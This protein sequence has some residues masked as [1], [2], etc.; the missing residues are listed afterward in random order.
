MW[1]K[2]WHIWIIIEINDDNLKIFDWYYELEISKNI[3][4]WS[5]SINKIYELWFNW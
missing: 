4:Y 2:Y 5:I 3:A 1:Y